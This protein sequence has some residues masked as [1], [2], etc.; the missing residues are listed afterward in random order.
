MVSL[1]YRRGPVSWGTSLCSPLGHHIEDKPVLP[2]RR[3]QR[4]FRLNHTAGKLSTMAPFSRPVGGNLIYKL[5]SVKRSHYHIF[6]WVITTACMTYRIAY[7]VII[8]MA[9]I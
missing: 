8:S 5:P 7:R 1:A 2:H 3:Q 6:L 9:N 4:P